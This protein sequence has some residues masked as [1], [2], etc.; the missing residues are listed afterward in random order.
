MTQ[1]PE[2]G[3][4]DARETTE[5]EE[6]KGRRNAGHISP[7]QQRTEAVTGE[8]AESQHQTEQGQEGSSVVDGAERE[9]SSVQ[10]TV[11]PPVL[12]DKKRAVGG[13]E[14]G[15]QPTEDPPGQDHLN[16]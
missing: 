4:W 1:Q 16:M 2:R 15:R 10:F 8:D 7:V 13:G 3:L 11:L 5:E 6:V 14:A 12:T 9:I